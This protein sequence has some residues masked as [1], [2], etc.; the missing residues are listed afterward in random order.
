MFRNLTGCIAKSVT[1]RMIMGQKWLLCDQASLLLIQF[2]FI[3][4]W[5]C[6]GGALHCSIWEMGVTVKIQIVI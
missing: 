1:K 6:V 5:K 3:G 2:D 4:V